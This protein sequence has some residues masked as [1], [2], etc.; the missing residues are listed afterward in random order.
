MPSLLKCPK[1]QATLPEG[2][3]CSRCAT[4][5]K[6]AKTTV[7]LKSKP[8][9]P[10][11]GAEIRRISSDDSVADL[12]RWAL[13]SAGL[14]I[15]LAVVFFGWWIWPKSSPTRMMAKA[16]TATLSEESTIAAPGSPLVE[17]QPSPPSAKPTPKVRLIKTEASPEFNRGESALAFPSSVPQDKVD[18]ATRRAVAYLKGN[19]NLWIKTGGHA[20]GY[21]SLPAL[22][23]LEAGVERTDP[24]IL[25]AADLVRK[26]GPKN[27]QTYEIALNILFLDKLGDPQ[28]EELIRTL[29]LRLIAGQTSAW[30]WN[31]T[32]PILTKDLEAPFLTALD[33]SRP[34]T[35]WDAPL[36]RDPGKGLLDLRSP[37][38]G[39]EDAEPPVA[40]RKP[41]ESK[42]GKLALPLVLGDADKALAMGLPEK[43]KGLPIFQQDLVK[44]SPLTRGRQEDNS[45]TQFALLALWA[46]RR[47]AV[48]TE[49]SLLLADQRFGQSQA[50]DGSWGYH[51]VQNR[52]TPSMTCVGLLGLAL[53]H[54][55]AMPPQRTSDDPAPRPTSDPAIERG[56]ASLALSIGDAKKAHAGQPP[57]LYFLWSL[58]RVAM[59]YRLPTIGGKDWYGWG[60]NFLLA[61]QKPGGN[62]HVGNYPG[63]SDPLDTAFAL[64]F[65]R[66]S[67]LVQDLTD[68]LQFNRALGK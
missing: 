35:S 44:T 22:A 62:W 65:L 51:L 31:Y 64:L 24:V 32:C 7:V 36:Q 14:A 27:Q 59:L 29:A 15:L 41:E 5:L 68:R 9:A 50:R 19:A 40:N 2:R 13:P 47:H 54:G 42:D 30:G 8:F 66:R 58:E 38:S 37:L 53:G 11:P 26:L 28:D 10:P 43:L 52:G 34:S 20:S 60:A 67:N 4:G 46:A 56:L 61:Q 12:P 39:K 45:N 63:A 23:L 21:A 17:G 48:P 25:K 3:V 57:N 18:E 6:T 55:A 16:D 49:R 33:K 1:C